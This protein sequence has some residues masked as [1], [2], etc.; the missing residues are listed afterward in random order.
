[1][2]LPKWALSVPDWDNCQARGGCRTRPC[3]TISP[4]PRCPGAKHSGAEIESTM[5]RRCLPRAVPVERLRELEMSGAIG[6]LNNLPT[7]C[8]SRYGPNVSP[9]RPRTFRNWVCPLSGYSPTYLAFRRGC[10][11]FLVAYLRIIRKDPARRGLEA[12]NSIWRGKP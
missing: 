10:L 9:E 3:S 6:I 12:R 2:C 7:S 4:S 11:I 1:M 8:L 5:S